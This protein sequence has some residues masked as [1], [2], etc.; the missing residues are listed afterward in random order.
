MSEEKEVLA[1]C[2][3]SYCVKKRGFKVPELI[4]PASEGQETVM[5]RAF[6][7]PS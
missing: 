1:E 5:R 3:C 2:N 6:G 4:G 7:L